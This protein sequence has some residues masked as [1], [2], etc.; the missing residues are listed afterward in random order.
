MKSWDVIVV[1]GGIIGLTLSFE[2]RKR[3]LSVVVLDKGEPGQEASWAAGGML[4]NCGAENPPA[5]KPLANTSAAMYP[6]FVAELEDASGIKVDLRSTGTLLFPAPSQS[7]QDI[8][9]SQT[10]PAPITEL[11][12]GLRW[13]GAQSPSSPSAALARG[14]WLKRL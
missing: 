5:L 6:E 2:L 1:G 12:P 4:A 11:E 8:P 14:C 10:L 13:E 3:G 7:A 9:G